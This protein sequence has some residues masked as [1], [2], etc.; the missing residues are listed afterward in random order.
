MYV[1]LLRDDR[2]YSNDAQLNHASL[3]RRMT[4]LVR[5]ARHRLRARARACVHYV[6]FHCTRRVFCMPSR[7]H[8]YG[9]GLTLGR[10][11]SVAI[12]DQRNAECPK[13]AV[14]TPSQNFP[15]PSRPNTSNTMAAVLEGSLIAF[16]YIEC[17]TNKPPEK[18]KKQLIVPEARC[19]AELRT[20]GVAFIST[21]FPLPWATRAE[22]RPL[23]PVST[24]TLSRCIDRAGASWHMW[25]VQVESMPLFIPACRQHLDLRICFSH[26]VPDASS[27]AGALLQRAAF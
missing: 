7:M 24:R 9:H 11:L 23:Q 12:S 1:S 26:L 5:T 21:T 8:A 3:V 25:N 27:P 10:F 14:A 17:T 6:F 16:G 22:L 15:K 20:F 13:A 19:D 4:G 18:T 2:C